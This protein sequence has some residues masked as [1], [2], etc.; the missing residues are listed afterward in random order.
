MRGGV[1]AAIVGGGVP[2]WV[3]RGD[4]AP[5][6][7]DIDF[8]NDRAWLN[9]GVSIAS[10]LT[11]TRAGTAN[12]IN[13]AGL[14]TSVS[15]NVLRYGTLGLLVEEA[16]TNLLLNNRTLNNASGGWTETDATVTLNDAVG[17]DGTASADKIE[18]TTGGTP[19][20]IS[21]TFTGTAA[22]YTLTAYVKN[23]DSGWCALALFNGT[24]E[25]LKNF[26]IATGAL[27]ANGANAPTTSTIEA[28]GSW[29]RVRITATMLV[30]TCTARLYVTD[31]DS[32]SDP[33]VGEGLWAEFLQVE[34]G[35][36]PTSPITT[37]GSAVTRAADNVQFNGIS[38]FNQGAGTAYS[39]FNVG[40][41]GAGTRAVYEFAAAA[42]A[43]AT[44]QRFSGGS[45]TLR[46]SVTGAAFAAQ[47]T[48]VDTIA[49]DTY[50]KTADVFAQDDFAS[51]LSGET[52]RTDTSG[53]WPA[54][55]ITQGGLGTQAGS[56]GL[57]LN[58]HIKR[59]AY[60]NARLANGALQAL[61]A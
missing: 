10:L 47:C 30:A 22:A 19:C 7:L 50:Y 28:V 60:W 39:E 49:V 58:G 48:L 51:S 9:G 36:F 16:R 18:S 1:R 41:I 15:A 14:L 32:A 34:L 37:A 45:G 12:Y 26:D 29:Y 8:V 6:T 55:T 42:R 20:L 43:D 40:T 3:L 56:A 25:Y 33:D 35:A 5:A 46:L 59:F 44:V 52:V 31:G 13:A 61:T 53:T 38:F 27:G 24:T 57:L 4:S 21:R 23:D 11:C 54:A 2:G 17:I